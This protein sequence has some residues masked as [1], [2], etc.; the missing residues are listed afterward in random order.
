M[1]LA[2]VGT[3]EELISRSDEM[4]ALKV[5][6]VRWKLESNMSEHNTHEN[7]IASERMT[8]FLNM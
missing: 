8:S 4:E 2:E 1:S 3:K 5:S 6:A 7:K